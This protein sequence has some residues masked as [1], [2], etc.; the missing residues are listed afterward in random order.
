M[1]P[2]RL[3]SIYRYTGNRLERSRS[4]RL[5]SP[6]DFSLSLSL[7]LSLRRLFSAMPPRKRTTRA[8]KAPPKAAADDEQ[9]AV[10]ERRRGGGGRPRKSKRAALGDGRGR[11]L[12]TEDTQRTHK[13]ERVKEK[14]QSER[15]RE[16]REELT[17]AFAIACGLSALRRLF[18]T[19][20]EPCLYTLS[21]ALSSSDV[22]DNE[23]EQSGD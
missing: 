22:D 5:V 21:E 9:D 1:N 23:M 18:C 12:H 7:S 11:S 4:E 3:F 14:E 2:S 15:E 6:C 13:R 10:R 8:A 19:Q 20:R 16:K 17:G